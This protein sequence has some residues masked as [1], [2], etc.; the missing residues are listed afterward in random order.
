MLFC[1]HIS[2]DSFGKKT[3]L[4]WKVRR[5]PGLLETRLFWK[6]WS[7]IWKK[8]A[9]EDHRYLP[10]K[11]KEWR[12]FTSTSFLCWQVSFT[13]MVRLQS[14]RSSCT[15][16][17]RPCIY[18][19]EIHPGNILNSSGRKA[20]CSCVSFLEFTTMLCKED[21]WFTSSIIR[22]VQA[23]K[24]SAGMSQNFFSHSTDR[25]SLAQ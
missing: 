20:W 4:F 2:L 13:K 21:L 19:D 17:G 8:V 6:V 23:S 25:S 11:V 22:T 15:A 9:R 1:L 14:I 12:S 5:C 18:C 16:S 24:V 10:R 3:R 7:L